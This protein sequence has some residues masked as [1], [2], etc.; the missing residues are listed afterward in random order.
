MKAAIRM[1]ITL[2]MLIIPLICSA[3][4]YFQWNKGN[5]QVLK[6]VHGAWVSFVSHAT[7]SSKAHRLPENIT[8]GVQTFEADEGKTFVFRGLDENQV[9]AYKKLNPTAQLTPLFYAVDGF[10]FP[11]KK[12]R[13]WWKRGTDPNTIHAVQSEYSLTILREKYIGGH[14]EFIYQL[15]RS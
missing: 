6:P 4:E 5:R 2:A 3:Q 1:L 10:K 8:Q 13:V 15:P 12:I 9:N 14:I 11:T 7:I